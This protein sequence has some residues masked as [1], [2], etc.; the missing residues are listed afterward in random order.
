MQIDNATYVLNLT[1]FDL[2]LRLEY[3]MNKTDPNV[4][5]NFDQY[6]SL[7]I[8]KSAKTWQNDENGD[9]LHYRV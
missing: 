9:P 1:N 6:I 5:K 8:S 4:M 2:A 7:K 3:I